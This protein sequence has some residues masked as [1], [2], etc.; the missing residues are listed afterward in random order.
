MYSLSLLLLFLAVYSFLGWI[1]EVADVLVTTKHLQNRGFLTGPFIPIYG[2]GAIALLL[3]VLPYINNP[4]LVFVASVL[5]TSTLEFFT[6]LALDKIFHIKLWDYS[7][8]RFNLQGRICLLNSILFG[9]LGL[10]L[11]YVLHPA[12][13]KLLIAIPHDVVIALGGTLTGILIVDAANSIR[14]LAKLR[15]VLDEVAGTLAQTHSRI[16]QQAVHLQNVFDHRRTTADLNHLATLSRL[17]KAF[18]RARSTQSSSST[19]ASQPR[20]ADLG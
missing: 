12:F 1:A 17:S 20:S 11:I 3:L 15:P 2:V 16:E 6:H 7:E 19:S 9:G 5:I 8:M 14:S 4:F 18:P 10:L 13:V